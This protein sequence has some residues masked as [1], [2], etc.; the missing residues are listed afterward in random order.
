MNATFLSW[1]LNV[2]RSKLRIS[3]EF[4]FIL[5]VNPKGYEVSEHIVTKVKVNPWMLTTLRKKK[6]IKA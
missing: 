3:R 5:G 6:P 2:V 1:F 4:S